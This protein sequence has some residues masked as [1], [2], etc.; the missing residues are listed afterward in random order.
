MKILKK[1]AIISILATICIGH[2]FAD[3]R[4]D[5]LKRYFTATSS[6][7]KKLE[8]YFAKKV[9]KKVLYN[10]FWEDLEITIVEISETLDQE[11]MITAFSDYYD[12]SRDIKY[13]GIRQ[14]FNMGYWPDEDATSKSFRTN[15]IKLN[16]YLDSF[17]VDGGE[18]ITYKMFE[19]LETPPTTTIQINGSMFSNNKKSTFSGLMKT[20]SP[21]NFYACD[22]CEHSDQLFVGKVNTIAI[23]FDKYYEEDCGGSF[24]PFFETLLDMEIPMTFEGQV[25]SISSDLWEGDFWS[26]TPDGKLYLGKTKKILLIEFLNS[27]VDRFS[28]LTGKTIRQNY[29][30]EG[31]G[32]KKKNQ[33]TI[34]FVYVNKSIDVNIETGTIKTWDNIFSP[35]LA[36][37]LVDAVM[38]DFGEDREYKAMSQLETVKKEIQKAY[39]GV[40]TPQNYCTLNQL[41]YFISEYV[42]KGIIR[43]NERTTNNEYCQSFL[44]VWKKLRYGN[45]WSS[46]FKKI[47]GKILHSNRFSI[48]EFSKAAPKTIYMTDDYTLTVKIR[49]SLYARKLK[50]SEV[51]IK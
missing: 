11:I 4:L 51:N 18:R 28:K 14:K 24:H 21:A 39:I 29:L 17:L 25:T 3:S 9:D 49:T 43:I 20:T 5:N 13:L 47:Y 22:G 45:K 10:T 23:D 32:I 34:S 15:Y 2:V 33:N 38:P 36:K 7:G 8:F 12:S 42:K 35:S 27:L 6:N 44:T 48:Y 26:A 16:Q 41:P 46:D 40:F 30:E 19:T 1:L 37:T 31:M 50:R